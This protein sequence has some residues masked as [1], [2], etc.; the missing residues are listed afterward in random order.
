VKRTNIDLLAALVVLLVLVG[1]GAFFA[2]T[3]KELLSHDLLGALGAFLVA[4]LTRWRLGLSKR[5]AAPPVDP[6]ASGSQ[7]EVLE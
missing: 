3:G 5:A 1:A 4:A 2:L 6:G 7:G